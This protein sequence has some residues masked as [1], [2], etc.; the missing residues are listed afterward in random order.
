MVQESYSSENNNVLQ[1]FNKAVGVQTDIVSD[2]SNFHQRNL[3]VRCMSEKLL[4]IWGGGNNKR[5]RGDLR[6]EFLVSCSEDLFALFRCMRQSEN[7]ANCCTSDSALHDTLSQLHATVTKVDY[8]GSAL[9]LSLSSSL[10]QCVCVHT[11]A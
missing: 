8:S 5:T 11:C 1:K 9:S 3:S 10:A 4:S 7:D 6:E 2:C